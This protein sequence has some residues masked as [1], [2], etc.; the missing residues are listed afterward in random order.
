[1]LGVFCWDYFFV[2]EN[3]IDIGEGWYDEVVAVLV[4][5]SVLGWFKVVA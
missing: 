5:R 1:M 2:L 4:G 3:I